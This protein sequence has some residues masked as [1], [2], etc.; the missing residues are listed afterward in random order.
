MSLHLAWQ[1]DSRNIT[2]LREKRRTTHYTK[3][4]LVRIH[5][6]R[7]C[8]ASQWLDQSASCEDRLALLRCARDD[9]GRGGCL[10]QTTM[11]APKEVSVDA[12]R[13]SVIS[14]RSAE[15]CTMGFSLCIRCVWSSPD[16]WFCPFPNSFQWRLLRW[17]CVTNNLAGEVI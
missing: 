7:L 13:A 10:R 11:A 16:P 12:T 6:R 3:I 1:L 9:T 15:N 4:H 14:G 2:R 17:F 8:L 5:V